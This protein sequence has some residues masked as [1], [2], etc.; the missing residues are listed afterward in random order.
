MFTSIDKAIAAAISALL[1]FAAL[2][3][4]IDVQALGLSP[5]AV[6]VIVSALAPVVVYLV[7]N[8]AS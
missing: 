5:D 2:Y 1:T 3:F 8:R 6:A 4:D 7:P